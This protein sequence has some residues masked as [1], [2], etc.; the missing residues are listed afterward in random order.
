MVGRR[1]QTE[2]FPGHEPKRLSSRSFFFVRNL[3]LC[4]R[5]NHPCRWFFRWAENPGRFSNRGHWVYQGA[6]T[7][8]ALPVQ[9]YSSHNFR[10]SLVLLVAP[11]V[12]NGCCH[13][14]LVVPFR[15][16]LKMIVTG[17]GAA[18]GLND[19]FVHPAAVS[20]TFAFRPLQPDLQRRYLPGNFLRAVAELHAPEFSE[21]GPQ[22]FCFA[23]AVLK[24]YFCAARL[25]YRFSGEI[26]LPA[27]GV[28]QYVP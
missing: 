15:V 10:T 2:R 11:P 5:K 23:F 25:R 20:V 18:V 19:E 17:T 6:I 24:F 22:V 28:G 4:K 26:A 8:T 9:L 16:G 3:L 14:R 21:P 7:K 27:R 13:W 1:A 12:T